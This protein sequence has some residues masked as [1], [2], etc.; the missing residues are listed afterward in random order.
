MGWACSKAKLSKDCGLNC[1][2]F[3]IVKFVNLMICNYYSFVRR[4]CLAWLRNRFV[5]IIYQFDD[6]VEDADDDELTLVG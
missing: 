2:N 1:S 5:E 6:A 3:F 4:L